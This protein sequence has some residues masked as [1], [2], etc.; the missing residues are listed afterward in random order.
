M[1]ET[2]HLGVAKA[3]IQHIGSVWM[4]KVYRTMLYIALIHDE[5]WKNIEGRSDARE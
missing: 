5:A 4:S 3:C 1:L 2:Y